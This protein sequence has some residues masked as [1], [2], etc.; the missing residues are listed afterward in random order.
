[1]TAILLKIY[2]TDAPR[3]DPG[4]FYFGAI[5]KNQTLRFIADINYKTRRVENNAKKYAESEA[6]IEKATALSEGNEAMVN[7]LLDSI[8]ESSEN[9]YLDSIGNE[10]VYNLLYLTPP[11]ALALLPY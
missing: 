5:S 7:Y 3:L 6:T 2:Y 4:V 11:E 10:T 9:Y 8:K 1:M